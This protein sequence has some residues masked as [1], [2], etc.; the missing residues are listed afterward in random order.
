M[1][2]NFK[3]EIPTTEN[4]LKVIGKRFS[5][6]FLYYKLSKAS[7]AATPTEIRKNNGKVATD[8]KGNSITFAQVNNDI[9]YSVVPNNFST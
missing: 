1:V 9:C 7:F 5:C 2:W 3:R 6:K 4:R 8:D